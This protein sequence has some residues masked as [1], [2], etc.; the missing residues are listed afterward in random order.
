MFTVSTLKLGMRVSV[1]KHGLFHSF[2]ARPP[3][4]QLLRPQGVQLSDCH[5]LRDTLLLTT[6][7][8][9]VHKR[10]HSERHDLMSHNDSCCVH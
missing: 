9:N 10:E 3:A 2:S 1:E 7:F 4:V 5:C 6:S 8:S